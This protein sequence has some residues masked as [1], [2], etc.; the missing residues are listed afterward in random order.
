MLNNSQYWKILGYLTLLGTDYNFLYNICIMYSFVTCFMHSCHLS[1]TWG[2][3]CGSAGKESTC[4]VGD[5]GLI[6]GLGRSSGE[7]KGSTLVLWPGEFHGLYGPWDCKE[8]DTTEQPSH[9]SPTYKGQ[10]YC[11]TRQKEKRMISPKRILLGNEDVYRERKKVTISWNAYDIW[12]P[13]TGSGDPQNPFGR[14]HP[15]LFTWD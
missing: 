7:G 10:S 5:P 2:F 9:S 6:S 1:S 11:V 8:S 4:N 12:P 3:P 15:F 13:I 14:D